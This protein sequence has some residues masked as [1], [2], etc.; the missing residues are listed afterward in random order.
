MTELSNGNKMML[1]VYI[2]SRF[3]DRFHSNLNYRKSSE[4]RRLF[5]GVFDVRPEN[6]FNYSRPAN[7]GSIPPKSY[8]PV[9]KFQPT[10]I[11]SNIVHIFHLTVGQVRPL[12][13][14]S[15]NFHGGLSMILLYYHFYLDIIHKNVI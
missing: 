14:K 8:K 7:A 12:C 4:I 10:A 3:T 13:K 15:R 6:A 5:F 9:R 1:S 2:F 11:T